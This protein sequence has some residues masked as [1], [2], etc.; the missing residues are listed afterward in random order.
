[1]HSR[2]AGARVAARE[3]SGGKTRVAQRQNPGDPRDAVLCPARSDPHD[4]SPWE[5]GRGSSS[6]SPPCTR[7]S[8]L[9]QAPGLPECGRHFLTAKMKTCPPCETTRPTL[10]P[11]F[12]KSLG[13]DYL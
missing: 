1:M 3:D 8:A 12:L 13:L 2:L 7:I 6:G 9:G 4:E 11:P 5:D 10:R